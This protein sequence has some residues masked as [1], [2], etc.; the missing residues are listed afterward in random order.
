M[1][2]YYKCKYVESCL[3]YYQLVKK[4]KYKK[5]MWIHILFLYINQLILALLELSFSD[6]LHIN[7]DGY[8][9]FK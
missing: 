8:S 3:V 5:R 1:T 6:Y 2:A 9:V 4:Y 7:L